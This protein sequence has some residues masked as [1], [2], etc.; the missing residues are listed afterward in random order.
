MR[1]YSGYKWGKASQPKNFND[2]I[3]KEFIIILFVGFALIQNFGYGLVFSLDHSSKIILSALSVLGV[4][5]CFSVRRHRAKNWGRFGTPSKGGLIKDGPN[6]FSRHPYYLGVIVWGIS[7]A[8][9]YGNIFLISISFV[10]LIGAVITARKEEKFLEI[11]FG[12][13]WTNYKRK[14]PFFIGFPKQ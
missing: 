4:F 2:F 9:L 11:E 10:W 14:T 1:Q 6:R 3:K 12:E 13:D 8:F 7:L 5:I